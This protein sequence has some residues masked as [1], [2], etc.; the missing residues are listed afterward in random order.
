MQNT[1]MTKHVA[2]QELGKLEWQPMH[3]MQLN[4]ALLMWCHKTGHSDH[5]RW[6]NDS[7]DS[8]YVQQYI[9]PDQSRN[10]QKTGMTEL[11]AVARLAVVQN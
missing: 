2:N 1:N 3:A 6:S 9:E 8:E 11:N 5:C 10:E 4:S 7:V